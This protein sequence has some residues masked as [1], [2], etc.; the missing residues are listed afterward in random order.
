M[1]TAENQRGNLGGRQR[2]KINHK[3][4]CADENDSRPVRG[5]YVSQGGKW[6]DIL[7][8]LEGE[9]VSL[10]RILYLATASFKNDGRKMLFQ[11][12]KKSRL[13]FQEMIE[14]IFRHKE[15]DINKHFDLHKK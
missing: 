6:S 11:Q 3:W 9:N 5:K 10:N 13:T 7:K 4:R 1:Q 14:E 8:G 2:K 15:Y 12:M